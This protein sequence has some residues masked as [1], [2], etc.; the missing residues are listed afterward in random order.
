MRFLRSATAL[1]VLVLVVAFGP[2]SALA[3][4]G[5]TPDLIAVGG[6]FDR[7]EGADFDLDIIP[8][9]GGAAY[10]FV[11]APKVSLVT[12]YRILAAPGSEGDETSYVNEFSVPIGYD[13]GGVVHFFAGPLLSVWGEG[14]TGSREQLYGGFAGATFD[15][16]DATSFVVAYRY[17]KSGDLIQSGLVFGPTFEIGSS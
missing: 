7:I 8:L 11:I 12:A 15:M 17:A 5:L 1:L 3:G 14:F 6:A 4:R 9:Q 13:A 16:D 2:Q 10:A